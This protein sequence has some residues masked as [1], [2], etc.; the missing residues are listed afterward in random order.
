M[1]CV[2]YMLCYVYFICYVTFELVNSDEY[3]IISVKIK[4]I[5]ID[6][7]ENTRYLESVKTFMNELKQAYKTM[8]CLKRQIRVD[9]PRELCYINDIKI[10]NYK[11]FL[12]ELS[13]T[14]LKKEA[15]MLCTQTSIYPVTLKLFNEFRD[16]EKH[17]HLSD[18]IEENPLTFYFKIFDKKHLSVEIE[19]RFKIIKIIDGDPHV[20]RILKVNTII[21]INDQDKDVYYSITD[22]TDT[23]L[24]TFVENIKQKTRYT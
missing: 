19:K 13:H 21:E 9:F 15:V 7:D 18:F 16:E 4:E 10:K 1:L 24:P 22:I 3:S 8:K 2:F 6:D 14:Y 23:M 11:Q 17:I 20:L 5:K 12:K